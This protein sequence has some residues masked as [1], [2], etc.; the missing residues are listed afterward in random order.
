MGCIGMTVDDF[1]QCT[2]L[3][4]S[5]V[6]ESWAE[7]EKRR[8]RAAWERTR[9]QC[10]TMLQPHSKKTLK[11]QD[12]LKFAWDTKEGATDNGEEQLSSKEIWERFENV[13]RKQG[14][15]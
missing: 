8:E 11:P 2:P 5:A 9:L 4:F 1:C 7:N 3:E 13:K 6:Y 14:L 10:T 15:V 12:V